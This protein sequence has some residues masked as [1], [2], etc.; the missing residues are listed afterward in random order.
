[1][2]VARVIGHATTTVRHPSLKGV[3]LLLCEVLDDA[4]LGT[5]A[6]IC[7]GDWIG[8]GKGDEVI[9]TSD[10]DAAEIHTKDPRGPLRSVVLEIIDEKEKAA[11]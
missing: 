3:R 2:V 1:M 11:S 8:A 6:V 5:G 9:V 10:G 7:A 4:G